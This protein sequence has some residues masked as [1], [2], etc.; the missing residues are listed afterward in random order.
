M[1][2]PLVLIVISTF[3]FC[4]GILWFFNNLNAPTHISEHPLT[5]I[6][7]GPGLIRAIAFRSI[8]EDDRVL[9]RHIYLIRVQ[10]SPASK[11]TL[12][13]VQLK[14][15][16]MD[17]PGN[18]KISGV[19]ETSTDLNPGDFIDFEIGHL[20]SYEVFAPISKFKSI[21]KS[22]F[23]ILFGNASANL[24]ELGTG[25]GNSTIGFFLDGWDGE[26]GHKG[27]PFQFSAQDMPPLQLEI[28]V[29]KDEKYRVRFDYKVYE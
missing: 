12:K 25:E 13:G 27:Q 8:P 5:I 29:L 24:F 10:N 9:Y 23:D 2:T 21:Q 7:T 20:D 4:V 3:V 15:W 6:G 11:K 1:V 17:A 22:E 28:Q 18:T 19:N 16:I 14:T 26:I